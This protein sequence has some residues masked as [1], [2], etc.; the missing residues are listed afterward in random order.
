MITAK[1][2]TRKPRFYNKSRLKNFNNLKLYFLN[3]ASSVEPL[4]AV[5]EA[6]PD[7]TVS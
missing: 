4:S 1:P 5:V 3:C 7:V 2:K 6:K